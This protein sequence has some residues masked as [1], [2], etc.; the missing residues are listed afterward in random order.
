MKVYSRA[1]WD[2][3][4]PSGVMARQE[5]PE[6]AF[7]H[8]TA[9]R[10]GTAFGL[11]TLAQQKAHLRGIQNYHM[12]SNG[13]H[14]VGYH[15]VVFQAYGLLTRARIFQGRRAEFVPAAQAA[16]NTGT[17]AICVVAA[18]G[19]PLKRNT[20]Y[21]IEQALARHPSLVTLGG[22]RDVVATSCPG[23]PIYA[24]IPQI[25][26]AAGLRRY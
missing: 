2:A 25:A 26:R 6:E 12:D 18:E 15:Y 19:E 1:E 7:L 13:W 4:P 22:H 8:Y 21:A 20:R 23:D 3:R 5:G 11:V 10:P 14:D 9:D 16:H 24:S 17:I